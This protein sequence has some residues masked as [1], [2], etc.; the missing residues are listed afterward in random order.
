[1]ATTN[2]P[3]ESAAGTVATSS[4]HL[5]Q[6]SAA[7]MASSSSK[8][9]GISKTSKPPTGNPLLTQLLEP[10]PRQATNNRRNADPSRQV[11]NHLPM[12][13]TVLRWHPLDFK[14]QWA[15]ILQKVQNQREEL[16]LQT[17]LPQP[18]LLWVREKDGEVWGLHGFGEVGG[19]DL[20]TVIYL[21][22][23]ISNINHGLR[24]GWGS[25]CGGFRLSVAARLSFAAATM[26]RASAPRPRSL[27]GLRYWAT[28][29][30]LL[31][32]LCIFAV[33]PSP[34]NF[35]S[36][37]APRLSCIRPPLGL[38]ETLHLSS[39]SALPSDPV[40]CWLT[41]RFSSWSV[42]ISRRWRQWGSRPR[43]GLVFSRFWT[44]GRWRCWGTRARLRGSWCPPWRRAGRR[45]RGCASALGWSARLAARG[46]AFGAGS[47]Y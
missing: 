33:S 38:V 42:G 34:P 1:M 32:F 19:E 17:M 4:S 40:R 8:A 23:W 21:C 22:F 20:Q 11:H 16:L 15:W 31:P 7:T 5:T 47:S 10:R 30:E 43:A 14:R 18:I 28:W 37:S 25:S 35:W 12:Q 24:I 26:R 39:F 13:V 44:S 3:Y 27:S 2:K 6:L 45:R 46:A 36:L 9:D 29:D 41:Q